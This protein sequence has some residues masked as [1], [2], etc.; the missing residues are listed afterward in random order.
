M[1]E[2]EESRELELNRF[3]VPAVGKWDFYFF[4]LFIFLWDL[5]TEI[6]T[7]VQKGN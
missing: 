7:K 5:L 3:Y 6:R 2:G 4:I 1:R